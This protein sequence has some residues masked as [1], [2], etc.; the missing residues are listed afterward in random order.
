M[1][2]DW[3]LKLVSPYG[4]RH[5]RLVARARRCRC[6]AA[7][8]DRHSV[9]LRPRRLVGSAAGTGSSAVLLPRLSLATS[10]Q[11]KDESDRREVT[12]ARM[13]AGHPGPPGHRALQAG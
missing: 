2:G 6:L 5:T 8:P 3:L 7:H 13:R 12:V 10:N 9:R 4:Y 11:C 1:N